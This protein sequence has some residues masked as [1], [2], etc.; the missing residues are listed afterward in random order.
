M[1]RS[2]PTCVFI[3]NLFSVKR[4]CGEVVLFVPNFLVRDCGVLSRVKICISW[5]P[6]VEACS[7]VASAHGSFAVISL[8]VFLSPQ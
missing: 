6:S 2:R 5:F 4:R 7:S 8:G 3:V 1:S